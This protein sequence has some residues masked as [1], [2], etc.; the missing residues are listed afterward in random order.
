MY[1]KPNCQGN[2]KG[3]FR[4]IKL[5]SVHLPVAAKL[6][7]FAAAKVHRDQKLLEVHRDQK[8]LLR[9][10]FHKNGPNEPN[11]STIGSLIIT[12]K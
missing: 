12:E 5:I 3:F 2:E 6:E 4:H 10:N 9:N 7:V 1:K 8:Q 11:F